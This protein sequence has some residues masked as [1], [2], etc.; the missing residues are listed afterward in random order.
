[1]HVRKAGAILAAGIDSETG[2][3]MVVTLKND[4]VDY[5]CTKCDFVISLVGGE[6]LPKDIKY[7]CPLK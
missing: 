1:M 4:A 2:E 6:K 5:K 3:E 7:G